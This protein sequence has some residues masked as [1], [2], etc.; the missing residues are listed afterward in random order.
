M[1]QWRAASEQRVR[2]LFVGRPM[3]NGCTICRA[4]GLVANARESE[5]PEAICCVG[6]GGQ[7]GNEKESK[8]RSPTPDVAVSATASLERPA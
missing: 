8:Q 5:T 3:E 4:L 1:L 6:G 7:R 2:S